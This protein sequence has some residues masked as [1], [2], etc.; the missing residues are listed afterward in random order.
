MTSWVQ[1]AVISMVFAGFTSVIAKQGLSGISG[2]LGLTVRTVFVFIFVLAFA[3]LF[4]S[5]REFAGLQARNYLW[6]GASGLTT[7]LSWI[8]YYKA[9][10]AGDVA[11]VALIDK[12]SV[13]V[14]MILAALVLREQI[15]PRMILGAALIVGGLLVIARR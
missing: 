4:V 8:F 3:L 10:K 5:R 6:L 15:T 11:T 7:A 12:G 9:L 1:Y 2:E 14:A 13:V